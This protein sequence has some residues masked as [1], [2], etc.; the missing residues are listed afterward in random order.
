[1]QQYVEEAGTV[2]DSSN[3]P[4]APEE[5]DQSPAAILRLPESADGKTKL[6]FQQIMGGLKA[7]QTLAKAEDFSQQSFLDAVTSNLDV[8]ES[9]FSVSFT[10]EVKVMVT[11]LRSLRDE[12]N[13]KHD[14][15]HQIVFSE[16]SKQIDQMLEKAISLGEQLAGSQAQVDKNKLAGEQRQEVLESLQISLAS[17]IQS[18][19]K[20]LAS[21]KKSLEFV[22]SQKTEILNFFQA[23]ETVHADINACSTQL[24]EV[25]AQGN[26][27]SKKMHEFQ[28]AGG[29]IDNEL[30]GSV[31]ALRNLIKAYHIEE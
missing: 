23:E 20:K 24:K 19:E 5:L 27:V 16:R 2:F 18:L 25:I 9:F 13:E 21:R 28:K 17:E 14:R 22:Q 30:P 8:W 6:A 31:Q 15:Q 10:E 12:P 1:V 11:K 3:L 7:L 26:S 4:S 29:D